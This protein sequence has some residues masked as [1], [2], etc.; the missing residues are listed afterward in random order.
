MSNSKYLIYGF[1]AGLIAIGIRLGTVEVTPQIREMALTVG[2]SLFIFSLLLQAMR[3]LEKGPKINPK[4]VN[5]ISGFGF[6]SSLTSFVLYGP[7][8]F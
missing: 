7:S 6:S 8:F 5:F 1:F 2:T 3:I 4:I